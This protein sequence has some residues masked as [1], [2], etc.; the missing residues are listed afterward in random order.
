[1]DRCAG[2]PLIERT[3][4]NRTESIRRAKPAHRKIREIYSAGLEPLRRKNESKSKTRGAH[5]NHDRTAASRFDRELYIQRSQS[6][7]QLSACSPSLR[8]RRVRLVGCAL[9]AR[10]PRL[11]QLFAR[12]QDIS[13]RFVEAAVDLAPFDHVAGAAARHKILWILLSFARTRH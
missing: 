13:L 11:P 3:S 4:A 2:S 9:H 6:P 5:L 7:K 10:F 1:S 8:R 12:M